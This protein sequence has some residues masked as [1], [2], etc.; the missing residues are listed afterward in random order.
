MFH[1]QTHIK[2][3]SDAFLKVMESTSYLY[4]QRQMFKKYTVK[5]EEYRWF[6]PKAFCLWEYLKH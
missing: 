1:G 4:F 5:E 6:S 3:K 2:K